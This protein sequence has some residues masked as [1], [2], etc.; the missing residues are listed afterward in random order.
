MKTL[1]PARWR[2]LR[3]VSPDGGFLAVGDIPGRVQVYATA[4]WKP[5]TPS[6]AGGGATRATFT[7][8]G[9]KLATGN[10]D[11]TVRLWDVASGQGRRAPGAGSRARSGLSSG[12]RAYEPAC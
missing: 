8:D 1:R 12:R 2:R 3:A 7:R 10:T 11:G 6:F 5:V 4:T 9:R